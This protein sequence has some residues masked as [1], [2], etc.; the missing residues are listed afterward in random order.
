MM[1]KEADPVWARA[2]FFPK[3]DEILNDWEIGKVSREEAMSLTEEIGTEVKAMAALSVN[4]QAD[5]V[6]WW[7]LI[8]TIENMLLDLRSH[9]I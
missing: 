8:Q 6:E 5:A 2:E 4:N 9:M 3:L 7:Y 1:L